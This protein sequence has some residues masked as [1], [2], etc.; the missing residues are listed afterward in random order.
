MGDVTQIRVVKRFHHPVGRVFDAFLDPARVGEW[1]FKTEDGVMERADFDPR[2]GGRFAIFERRGEDLAEHFGEFIEIV[3]PERVVFDF[4]AGD[5]PPVRITILFATVDLGCEVSL[6]HELAGEWANY[7]ERT[8][9]GWTTIL[10]GLD[11][12]LATTD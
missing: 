2:P 8:R 11:R 4:S 12:V 9:R 1:L 5:N 10:D 6:S 3:R 7:A